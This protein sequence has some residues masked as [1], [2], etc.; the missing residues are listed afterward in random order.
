MKP[1]H[2]LYLTIK[3]NKQTVATL[4]ND[5]ITQ[6]TPIE[7]CEPELAFVSPKL[8]QTN[9]QVKRDLQNNSM[10]DT[11]GYYRKMN[12]K[13]YLLNPYSNRDKQELLNRNYEIIELHSS[14]KCN[15]I[16]SETYDPSYG[17]ECLPLTKNDIKQKQDLVTQEC[18][19][20][21]GEQVKH[22]KKPL[23][24]NKQWSPS[25]KGYQPDILLGENVVVQIINGELTCIVK[26]NSHKYHVCKDGFHLVD[27]TIPTKTTKRKRPH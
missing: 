4:T 8:K 23:F 7:L 26:H 18:I 6:T 19:Q 27:A 15:Q 2:L 24:I 20:L 13:Y 22:N 3:Y 11:F 12:N 17:N 25:S 1:S 10:I 9:I 21:W 14:S 16:A 5:A